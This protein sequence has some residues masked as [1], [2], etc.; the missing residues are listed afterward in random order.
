MVGELLLSSPPME[1]TFQMP[2]SNRKFSRI[3][4]SNVGELC[5]GAYRLFGFVSTANL[6]CYFF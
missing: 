4:R 3:K 1:R 2:R 6:L 5:A